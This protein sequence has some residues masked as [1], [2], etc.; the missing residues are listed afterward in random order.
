MTKPTDEQIWAAVYAASFVAEARGHAFERGYGWGDY[1][2]SDKPG[3]D[4]V[5]AG[6]AEDAATLANWAV[7]ALKRVRENE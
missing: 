4:D 3:A 6:N 7:E 2:D 1:V 5:A